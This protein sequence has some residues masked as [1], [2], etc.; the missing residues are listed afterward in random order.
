[1][2]KAPLS[3]LTKYFSF[4]HTSARSRFLIRAL[5]TSNYTTL[6]EKR[7]AR[8]FLLQAPVISDYDSSSTRSDESQRRIA[9]RFGH[10][11]AVLNTCG[12]GAYRFAAWNSHQVN[13][14][15]TVPSRVHAPCDSSLLVSDSHQ[16]H[17]HSTDAISVRNLG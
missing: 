2:W 12:D 4:K 6:D 13:P 16:Q 7:T 8:I 3:L 14:R 11:S 1:M 15:T 10:L 17:T 9:T 5:C